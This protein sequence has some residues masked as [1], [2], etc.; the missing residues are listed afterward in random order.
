MMN[1]LFYTDRMMYIRTRA[2]TSLSLLWCVAN[3][4][5]LQNI[6]TILLKHGPA[7]G[8]F[9]EGDDLTVGDL[10]LAVTTYHMEAAF[11]ID[12]QW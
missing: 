10:T 11:S 4:H 7:R 6:E 9:V 1:K 8:P 2:S 3:M 12:Q 5:S